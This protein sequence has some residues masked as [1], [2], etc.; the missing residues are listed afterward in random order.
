MIRHTKMRLRLQVLEIAD[1]R[2]PISECKSAIGNWQSE[3]MIDS[4]CHLTDPRLL[5]QLDEFLR[6]GRRSERGWSSPSARRRITI[7]PAL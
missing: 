6:E 3:I 4:H 7:T 2:L 5:S 1:F